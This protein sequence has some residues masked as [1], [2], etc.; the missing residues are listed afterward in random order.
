VKTN[1]A[2]AS[3]IDETARAQALLEG[4]PDP[5]KSAEKKGG[6]FIIQVAAL[7]SRDKVNELQIKLQN[8]GIKSYTQKVATQSGDRT[9]IR[10]GPF[11]SKEEAEKVR[12]KIVKLGLNGTLMPA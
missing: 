12:M 3:S 6:K 1:T 10:V 4:K 7:A 8:A 5:A 9:R 11:S 2:R